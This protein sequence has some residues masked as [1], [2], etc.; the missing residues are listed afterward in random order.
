MADT[1]APSPSEALSS[2][3]NG[4]TASPA[5]GEALRSKTVSDHLAELRDRLPERVRN[6]GVWADDAEALIRAHPLKTVAG[7]FVSG[8]LVGYLLRGRR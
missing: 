6:P 4:A 1:L 5:P 2:P 3:G 7:V 8:L